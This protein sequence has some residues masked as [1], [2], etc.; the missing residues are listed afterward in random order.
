MTYEYMIIRI[1]LGMDLENRQEVSEKLTK[2]GR[3]G[4][5]IIKIEHE[6][7]GQKI[8]W[9]ERQISNTLTLT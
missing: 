2:A 3:E 7:L 5:R 9:L 4:W 1:N 8:I 6:V